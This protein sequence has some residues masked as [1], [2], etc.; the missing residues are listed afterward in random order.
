MIS[1]FPVIAERDVLLLPVLVQSLVGP[2]VK[3]AL[4]DGNGAAA[5]K[6]SAVIAVLVLLLFHF[7]SLLVFL[8]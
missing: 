6:L 3:I 2:L 1:E 7:L 4:L 8:L 5:A